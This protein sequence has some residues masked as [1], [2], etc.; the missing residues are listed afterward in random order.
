M[1]LVILYYYS[2]TI[3]NPPEIITGGKILYHLHFIDV[4]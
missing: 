3:E 4:F 2:S 1:F